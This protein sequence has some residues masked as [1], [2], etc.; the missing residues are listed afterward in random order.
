MAWRRTGGPELPAPLA[1]R[2]VADTDQ[3]RHR[4]PIF[5][6]AHAIELPA[7]AELIFEATRRWGG[8]DAMLQRSYALPAPDVGTIL[9]VLQAPSLMP[10]FGT[11]ET[12]ASL[13]VHDRPARYVARQDGADLEWEEGGTW[14]RLSVDH[15]SISG[16]DLQRLA[17]RSHVP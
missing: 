16:D 11:G 5:D 10:P 7:D 3:G 8:S 14:H 2:P 15:R 4:R 12:T 17:E 6:G 9:H 13:V 1:G